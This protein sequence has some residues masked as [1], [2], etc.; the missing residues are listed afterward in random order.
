E[1]E[2]FGFTLPDENSMH[3]MLYYESDQPELYHGR[4]LDAAYNRLAH[5]YRVELVHQ[6]DEQ[7]VTAAC[8]RVSGADFTRPRGSHCPGDGVGNVIATRSFYGAGPEF[9]DRETAWAQSDAWMTFLRDKLPRA[10]TFLY[11]PDEPR[12]SEY[13]HILKLAANIH[14]N[15]GP[16]KALPIFVTSTYVEPLDGAI[17]I[18]CSGPKGFDLDRVARE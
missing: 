16:G 17:D 6:Y 11:M 4:N 10:L 13:P 3:A 8:G 7:S 12:A 1:L 14:S 5:R 9:E 2:V 15:P 18:W